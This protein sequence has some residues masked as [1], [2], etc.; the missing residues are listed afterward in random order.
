MKNFLTIAASLL[1]TMPAIAAPSPYSAPAT[2]DDPAAAFAAVTPLDSYNGKVELTDVAPEGYKFIGTGHLTDGLIS[3][4]LIDYNQYTGD[5]IDWDVQVLQSTTNENV[6]AIYDGWTNGNCPWNADGSCTVNPNKHSVV[7]FEIIDDCVAYWPDNDSGATQSLNVKDP[8]GNYG[9]LFT[10]GTGYE[11]GDYEDGVISFDPNWMYFDYSEGNLPKTYRKNRST[12]ILELPKADEPVTPPADPD[13]HLN[14]TALAPCAEGGI[15]QVNIDAGADAVVKYY[16]F[17]NKMDYQSAY[18]SAVAGQGTV[19]EA[20]NQEINLNN[21]VFNSDIKTIF[22]VSLDPNDALRAVQAGTAISFSSHA[23]HNADA[24]TLK[25]VGNYTDDTLFDEAI[26]PYDVNVYESNE[27]PGLY[28]IEDLFAN[29]PKVATGDLKAVIGH[30]H[31]VEI[32][33]TN[34]AA[35]KIKAAPVGAELNGN[36]ISIMSEEDGTLS[37]SGLITFPTRGLQY[38][39]DK[40]GYANKNG[41][42]AIQLPGYGAPA[43]PDYTFSAINTGSGF[44]TEDGKLAYTV[45]AGADIATIK[46]NITNGYSFIVNPDELNEGLFKWAE[47]NYPVTMEYGPGSYTIDMSGLPTGWISMIV[48]G[49]N[50]EGDRVAGDVILHY[51]APELIESEWTL[52]G[53]GKL[54]DDTFLPDFQNNDEVEAYDV[55]VY[56]NKKKA[57]YYR[58]EEPYEKHPC[59]LNGTV[60]YHAEYPHYLDIDASAGKN[61]VIIPGAPTGIEIN[62]FHH[63]LASFYTGT[64]DENNVVTFPENGLTNVYQKGEKQTIANING[65]F[66]VQIP[67]KQGPVNP[68]LPEYEVAISASS[69][70]FEDG[71]V[72]LTV[73]GGT[74]IK[75]MWVGNLAGRKD[76]SPAYMNAIKAIGTQTEASTFVQGAPMAGWVTFLVVGADEY[77]D[78]VDIKAVKVYNDS[79]NDY[80][81]ELIG[82][83]KIYDSTYGSA[84][85]LSEDTHSYSVKVYESYDNRGVYR[86][87][88]P[89]A[90]HPVV[91][92]ATFHGHVHYIEVDASGMTNGERYATIDYQP[93]GANHEGQD[94]VVRSRRGGTVKD[95]VITF[96]GTGIEYS[97]ESKSYVPSA[98]AT[99]SFVLP[100][101]GIES[102]ETEAGVDADAVIYDLSGR[103]INKINTKGLY[104]VNGQKVIR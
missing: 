91:D 70:C 4:F 10:L 68:E 39:A 90:N 54:T 57:G 75:N 12:F 28:C 29:H 31:Y 36:M 46:Y 14:V 76:A 61:M 83:G 98:D 89:F 67:K 77:G 15:A 19:I 80:D 24:W 99:L 103:R 60:Q 72:E 63:A 51:N 41:R 62:G 66:S 79:Y 23:V 21:T 32:D 92:K 82:D 17:P 95:G 34:P 8:W 96:T 50:K 9:E 84:T 85:G 27:T 44:C 43:P 48:M 49:Y 73:Q 11:S 58:I 40:Y 37:E 87:E 94:I 52:L 81:W 33:A 25:G 104:I 93:T 47:E 45:T 88:D 13:F 1:M 64:I 71:A 97:S 38:Q 59:V 69:V 35:V 5:K 3:S 65:R 20:G 78:L 30:K 55:T 53:T 6:Y 16:V 7:A 18:G 101:S 86:F 22:F 42:F 2:G 26:A 100:A 102:I 56:E 74:G